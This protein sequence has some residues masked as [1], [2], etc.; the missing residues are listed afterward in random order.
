[1]FRVC[2]Q[3]DGV[4]AIGQ[5][6]YRHRDSHYYL[7]GNMN[8]GPD[9]APTMWAYAEQALMPNLTM[10]LAYSHAFGDN[11]PCNDFCG[12]GARYVYKRA[13][14]G[15]FSDFTSVSDVEEDASDEIDEF[16]TEFVCELHLTDYLS[17]KPVLHIITTDD[18]TKYVGMLR[19]KLS[20]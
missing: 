14:F 9:S 6:E 13:E 20:F 1:M 8:N 19:V 11:L 18:E 16:A 3:S 12:I 5:V 7:G 2:P 10:I 17:V 15:I 4:F